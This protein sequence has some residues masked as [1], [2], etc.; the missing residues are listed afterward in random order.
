MESEDDA[1]QL[2]SCPLDAS[3]HEL[4]KAWKSI[5][6]LMKKEDLIGK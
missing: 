5:N 4:L 3:K 1:Y 6:P 2:T